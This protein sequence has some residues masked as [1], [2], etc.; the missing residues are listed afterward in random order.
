[1]YKPKMISLLINVSF[2]FFYFKHIYSFYSFLF[3][4]YVQSYVSIW[5][6]FIFK[7]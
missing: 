6:K 5:N 4:F 7:V 2:L 1:M 3:L